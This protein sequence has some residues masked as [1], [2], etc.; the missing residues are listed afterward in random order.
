MLHITLHCILLYIIYTVYTPS[1]SSTRS[2]PYTSHYPTVYYTSSSTPTSSIDLVFICFARRVRIRGS[3]PYLH[4]TTNGQN[5]TNGFLT[6]LLSGT[7]VGGSSLRPLCRC[8]TPPPPLLGAT[9][10]A[11]A[12]GL[13]FALQ[14][15][16]ER[17]TQAAH[18]GAAR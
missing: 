5:T 11:G 17:R 9:V 12:D 15:P 2:S 18:S 10:A 3:P 13:H 6:C 16:A 8:Y 1:S 14:S 4:S 7:L